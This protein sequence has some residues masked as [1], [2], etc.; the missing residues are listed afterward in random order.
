MTQNRIYRRTSTGSYSSTPT[1]T[2]GAAAA[3]L[4]IGLTSGVSYCYVV[5]AVGTGQNESAKSQP[6]ACVTAK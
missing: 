6:E 5:T 4:D 1:R 2:M 3:Y